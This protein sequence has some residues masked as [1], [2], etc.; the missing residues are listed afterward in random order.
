MSESGEVITNP[1]GIIIRGYSIKSDNKDI[2]LDAAY[3]IVD[4]GDCE[5]KLKEYYQLDNKTELYIL[6]IDSPNKNKSYTTSVYNYEVYLENGTQL[7]H[8]SACHNSK[9]SISSVITNTE[10]VKLEKAHY[11]SDLGYDIYEENNTFI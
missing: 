3:S 2:N 11:F 5:N 6:G 10:L 9:I 1:S 7:D 8:I 4:L